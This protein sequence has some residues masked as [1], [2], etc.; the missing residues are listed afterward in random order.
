MLWPIHVAA[1]P[2]RLTQA[3]LNLIVI[4]GDAVNEHGG[5]IRLRITCPNDQRNVHMTVSDHSSGKMDEVK[6]HA[7]DPFLPPG[8]AAWEPASACRSFTA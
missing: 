6:R 2:H 3:A 8:R 5:M 7:I 4:A 1:A